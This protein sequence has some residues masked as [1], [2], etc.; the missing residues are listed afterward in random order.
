MDDELRRI[1]P[2]HHARCNTPRD[3]THNFESA[4]RLAAWQVP[5]T[6][7]A[8]AINFPAFGHH[9]DPNAG[10]LSPYVNVMPRQLRDANAAKAAAMQFLN[11][12]AYVQIH[13]GTMFWFNPDCLH[14]FRPDIDLLTHN[15]VDYARLPREAPQNAAWRAAR[16]KA[17]KAASVAIDAK[18]GV[19]LL[20]EDERELQIQLQCG[21]LPMAGLLQER[22]L[23]HMRQQKA[24]LKHSAKAAKAKRQQPPASCNTVTKLPYGARTT[25]TAGSVAKMR[26]RSGNSVQP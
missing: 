11:A 2:T 25:R 8:C 4:G 14:A 17:R 5:Q 13:H 12:L 22:C 3:H 26:L 6:T 23:S 21:P 16:D 24:D 15:F 7:A 10:F 1:C 20:S 19:G 18:S 9:A